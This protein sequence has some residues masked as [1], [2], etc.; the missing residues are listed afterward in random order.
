MGG[1]RNVVPN[2]DKRP[3]CEPSPSNDVPFFRIEVFQRSKRDNGQIN[4]VPISDYLFPKP[5]Q[6]GT[7]VQSFVIPRRELNSEAQRFVK[8]PMQAALLGAFDSSIV[9]E[10]DY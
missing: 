8:N 6:I 3:E 4:R 2:S 9:C 7:A 1:E 5:H 10:V